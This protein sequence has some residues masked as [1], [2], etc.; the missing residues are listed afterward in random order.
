[1]ARGK[2]SV[3]MPAF[4]ESEHIEQ[5]VLETIATL[6]KLNF[7][8]EVIVV[9]DGSHDETYRHAANACASYPGQVRVVRY[10]VNQG[11][12]NA[13]IC[14]TRYASGDF[15]VF[16][17][18]DMDLHPVQL[19]KF[20]S[21]LD[22]TKADA[23][24]GSK[25][26]PESNVDYPFIR[27][28]YSAAYYSVVRLLFGLPIRDTQTGLKLFKIEVLRHVFPRVLAKR[29]AFDI[30]LLANAHRLGYKIV[31]A[32]VNLNFMRRYGRINMNDVRAVLIDTMAIFYRMHII[33]YYDRVATIDLADVPASRDA[34]E[35]GTPYS[36]VK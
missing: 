24:I 31:E 22:E 12:G 19:P 2:V 16:L 13:L 33:R 36:V 1:M 6:A 18:S 23:V 8:C 30:E 9:D 32:P 35:V 29:F 4:N 21:I 28:V 27:R 3:I 15:V 25:R 10:D 5:N 14:G 26:H 11:K 7:D 34:R 20:F 17:D